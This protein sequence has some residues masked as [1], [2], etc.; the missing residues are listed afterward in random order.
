M[1]KYFPQ[2]DSYLIVQLPNERLRA[3]I[4]RVVT[5]DAVIV[6]ITS[7]PLSRTHTYQKGDYVACRRT[8]TDFGDVWQSVAEQR[9]SVDQVAQ[10]IAEPE[11]K[12][13][14]KKTKKMA[15]VKVKQKTAPKKAKKK[16][17]K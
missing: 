3:I 2:E 6:E 5:E 10:T 12:T 16:G 15:S 17:I 14:V 7:I 1:A 13:V 8:V 9:I 11:V 4:R